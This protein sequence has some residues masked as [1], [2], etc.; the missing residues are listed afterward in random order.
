MMQQLNKK[1]LLFNYKYCTVYMLY[2]KSKLIL[3]SKL[4]NAALLYT[5]YCLLLLKQ[6]WDFDISIIIK[7]TRV[8]TLHGN[9]DKHE[10]P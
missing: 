3:T 1:T 9:L 10:K 4:C 6:S 2:I 5:L 8:A 7:L